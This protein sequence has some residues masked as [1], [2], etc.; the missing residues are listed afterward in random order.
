ML[1]T[2]IHM[3]TPGVF[4]AADSKERFPAGV[5]NRQSAIGACRA[6]SHCQPSFPGSARANSVFVGE[7]RV[8]P[9][10]FFRQIFRCCLCGSNW[11]SVRSSRLL[12]T[13][14]LATPGKSG[15]AVLGYRCSAV[16]SSLARSHTRPMIGISDATSQ[17]IRSCPSGRALAARTGCVQQKNENSSGDTSRHAERCVHL[18]AHQCRPVPGV[19]RPQRRTESTET[20]AVRQVERER[21]RSPDRC[22]GDR[23]RPQKSRQE[24][25]SWMTPDT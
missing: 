17:P 2:V 25:E 24:A 3:L 1:G 15:N 16:N 18:T 4:S 8:F 19:R 11:S 13:R 5:R 22:R 10:R 21:F 14:S 9:G 20:T 7:A 23:G 12:S 6:A